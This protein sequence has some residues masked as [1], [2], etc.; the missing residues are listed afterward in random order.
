MNKQG[1]SAPHADEAEKVSQAR[2]L[3]RQ[4]LEMKAKARDMVNEV[5]EDAA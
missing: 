2:G 5:F 1:I 4:N 3:T